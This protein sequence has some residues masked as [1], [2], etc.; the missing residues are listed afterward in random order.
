[1]KTKPKEKIAIQTLVTLPKSTT[2][3]SLA[4]QTLSIE[5]A[6]LQSSRPSPNTF[7]GAEVASF[8]DVNLYEVIE[9]P[10][11]DYANITIKQTGILQEALAKKKHEELLRHEHR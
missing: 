7:K 2:S 5:A 8:V 10:K 4:L 3:P 1:M 9:F 11:F 6:P